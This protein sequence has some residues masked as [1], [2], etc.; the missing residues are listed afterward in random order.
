MVF[1]SEPWL[2]HRQQPGAALGR[3]LHRCQRLPGVHVG[4]AAGAQA[5]GHREKAKECCRY[6]NP[7]HHL[8]IG[9]Y[10]L[11]CYTRLDEEAAVWDGWGILRRGDT[12]AR[13]TVS[14]FGLLE[15]Y[16]QPASRNRIYVRGLL[17]ALQ[18]GIASL[19]LS[20][21][22]MHGERRKAL[23]LFAQD[24]FSPPF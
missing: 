7:L 15:K 4:G 2:V 22:S 3:S 8:A 18:A 21:D 23:H 13:R 5:E 9:R 16:I 20:N 1:L 12:E 19:D 11:G 17:F 10:A 6:K 14:K 24:F